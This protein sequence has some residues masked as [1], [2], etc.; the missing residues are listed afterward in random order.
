ML[1]KKYGQKNNPQNFHLNQGLHNLQQI[2]KQ[3]S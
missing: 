3:L 1:W 2:F